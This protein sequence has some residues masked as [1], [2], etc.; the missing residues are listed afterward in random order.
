MR[1]QMVLVFLVAAGSVLGSAG[2]AQ[3]AATGQVAV[4]T[5]DAVPLEVHQDPSGCHQL[6]YSAQ[7]LSNLTDKPVKVYQ[8]QYCAGGAEVEVLPGYGMN[9]QGAGSFWVMP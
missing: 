4:Y 6:P 2:G 1:A 7:V 5:A 8:D 3:A 9:V